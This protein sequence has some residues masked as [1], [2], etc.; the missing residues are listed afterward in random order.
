MGSESSLPALLTT[1]ALLMGLWM[2]YH[3]PHRALA[4]TLG[5]LTAS[6]FSSFALQALLRM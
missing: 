4:Y 5:V 2:I 1:M 6:L 3:G